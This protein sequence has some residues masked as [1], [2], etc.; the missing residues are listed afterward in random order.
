M[1]NSV[2]VGDL[3]LL[4]EDHLPRHLWRTS[5]RMKE[6]FMGRDGRVAGA[7]NM[8]SCLSCRIFRITIYRWYQPSAFRA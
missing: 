8:F 5:C 6:T 7:I 1:H 2:L 4:K 3:A